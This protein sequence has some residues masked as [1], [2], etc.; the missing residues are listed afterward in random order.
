MVVSLFTNKKKG[1]LR[2]YI[3]LVI[4]VILAV[5]LIFSGI[6]F[7]KRTAKILIENQKQQ[8]M[9]ELSQV[10]Q[11]ITDQ[12]NNLDYVNSLFVSNTIVREA[13][14]PSVDNSRNRL[15]IEKQMSFLLINTYMWEQNYI[16]GV[17]IFLNPSE[18]YTATSGPGTVNIKANQKILESTS[19]SNPY[20]TIKMQ[21]STP[22]VLY[23]VRNIFSSYTGE[24]V[25]TIIINVNKNTLIDF[26]K[27]GIDREWFIYLYNEEI[28]LITDSHDL[29]CADEISEKLGTLNKETYLDEIDADGQSYLTA[30]E[31]LPNLDLTSVVAAPKNQVLEKLNDTLRTYILVLAVIVMLVLCISIILSRAVTRPIGNMIFQINKIAEGKKDRLPS[32]EMYSEFNKLAEAFNHMLD[33]LDTYYKDNLEKQLLLK[34]AEIKALQSQMDPH[35]MFNTLN[36]IAWKAQMTN[37]PE[38]YQ[39]VISLGELLKANVISKDFTYVDLEDELRYVKFYT[40][41]QKM[42]FEDKISVEIQADDS[43]LH[44]K[45]PCFCI[46]PLVENSIVHGLEPK[47]G[48][49]KLAV[50]VIKHQDCMEI[51]VADNGIGFETIPHICDIRPS[52]EES[53]TH[54]GLRNLDRRLYLLF[55]E[56]AHLKITSTLNV[57]TTIS[58]KLPLITEGTHY[59]ISPADR[60]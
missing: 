30:A 23:F 48:M 34:N 32:L 46:Q 57:C 53:H 31:K 16:N 39:M 12:V 56:M 17:C 37:N 22:S 40:Y 25:A 49:G 5:S 18:Y 15:D 20:L 24:Y 33:K 55:G 35:F 45:V 59:D 47:K 2:M 8:V 42:R 44:Y 43:L 52:S 27:A 19:T 50:N 14:E 38:I 3:T 1:T 4:T 11:N 51:L 36:T 13:I 41:L 26:Y 29:P 9:K 21:E 28:N 6:F 7:Y 60:G 10:N 54:I 58:F